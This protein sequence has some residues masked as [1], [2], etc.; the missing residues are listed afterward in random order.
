M[1][2]I[3]TN[4]SQKIIACMLV[5]SPIE[6][7]SRTIRCNVCT[8]RAFFQYQLMIYLSS[9]HLLIYNTI[10]LSCYVLLLKVLQKEYTLI[11]FTHHIGLW[12]DPYSKLL[13]SYHN[14]TQENIQSIQCK[15]MD[16]QLSNKKELNFQFLHCKD[17]LQQLYI[18][19]Q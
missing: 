5:L 16:K 2:N 1:N 19:R 17:Q 10:Q 6:N 9:A 18:G 13:L 14:H 8:Q 3:R 7:C 15:Q 11:L 4:I 12:S